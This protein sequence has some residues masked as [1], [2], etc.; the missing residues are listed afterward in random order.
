MSEFDEVLFT[1]ADGA[2]RI[3]LNRP[4]ALNALSVAC[5]LYTSRCV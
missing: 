5:L 1:V 4:R 3:T 2:G